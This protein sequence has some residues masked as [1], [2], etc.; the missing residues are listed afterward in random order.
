[1]K[2]IRVVLQSPL[3]LGLACAAAAQTR[4]QSQAAT[5]LSAA[6]VPAAASL[7]GA[8]GSHYVSSLSLAN[9]HPFPIT[10]TAYLLPANSDNTNY[11]SGAKEIPLAAN[12]GI[13]IEDP[14]AALWGTSGLAAIYLESTPS[15]GN[16]AAFAV[17]SRVLNVANP[18]ATFGLSLP[19]TLS[20][21]SAGDIGLA[22]DIENDEQF[23]TNFGLFNDSSETV[24]VTVELLADDGV[25]LGSKVFSLPPYSLSQRNVTE[26]ASATFAHA[27]L[28]VTPPAGGSGQVIGYTAVVDNATGDGAASLLQVY[29]LPNAAV[30]LLVT[31]SRYA[32]TPG[33]P[34]AAP[35]R[36]SAGVA[37]RITFRSTD[38]E[39]GMSAVPQL[40]IEAASIL[41]GSDYVVTV[42]PT[43]AQRGSYNF[44]CT[45]VCGAGHGGMY[46]VIEV[47]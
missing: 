40:G 33:G 36:L 6:V 35:I 45:R 23:R 11:R 47:E 4:T 2:A 17:D 10:V 19:G 14:L 32:F 39:H 8:Y 29:R 15:S 16:D 25:V 9:P 3:L 24:A 27:T 42:T 13:R 37:Y 28:R 20:G 5:L 1:M 12:G 22:S 7:F 26:I 44:A 38:T 18:T 30:P 41:P 43:A 21:V 46:G 34:D 31:L